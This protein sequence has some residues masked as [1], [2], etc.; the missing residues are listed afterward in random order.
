MD[1]LEEISL[2]EE[3]GQTEP[4]SVFMPIGVRRQRQP[5]QLI[6]PTRRA[7]PIPK[8]DEISLPLS[9]EFQA[10]PNEGQARSFAQ[11]I[12]EANPKVWASKDR[13]QR[14]KTLSATFDI[15]FSV[16]YEAEPGLS[17]SALAR[18]ANFFKYAG[19]NFMA[20]LGDL[21][22]GAGKA[23]EWAFG[24]SQ[25]SWMLY[26]Q[27]TVLQDRYAPPVKPHEFTLKSVADPE[28]WASVVFRNA[29]TTIGLAIAAVPG[30]YALSGAAAAFGATAFATALSY[31]ASSTT[32]AVVGAT[33]RAILQGLGA[34]ALMRP[35]ESA[36]EAGETLKQGQEAGLSEAE[37]L[38]R[39]NYTF[40]HNMALA[41]VDIAQIAAA[42]I[43]TKGIINPNLLARRIAAVTGKLGVVA[44]TESVEEIYQAGIQQSAMEPGLGITGALRRFN[45]EM[46]EAGAVGAIFGLGLGGAGS[47][48]TEMIN[49]IEAGMTPAQAQVYEQA[50]LRQEAKGL[51]P[52]TAT[53]AALD[54]FAA[55]PE[56]Y[57]SIVNS[58]QELRNV[59]EGKPTPILPEQMLAEIQEAAKIDDITIPESEVTRLLDEQQVFEEMAKGNVN[60]EDVLEL[61]PAPLPNWVKS[62]IQSLV[63]VA[64]NLGISDEI[65]ALSRQRLTAKQAAQ[66]IAENNPSISVSDAQ[67][68]V[69]AVRADRGIPSMDEVE[70]FER[71]VT[72]SVKS[73]EGK[74]N[75][76]VSEDS[77]QQA[78]NNIKEKSKGLHANIDPTIL[79]DYVK[80]GAYH[81][82][83][84]VR[85]LKGKST[86]IFAEWSNWMLKHFDESIRPNLQEIFQQ[87]WSM[88]QRG[89]APFVDEEGNRII[90][91]LDPEKVQ[92]RIET[93]KSIEEPTQPTKAVKPQ[94]RLTTGQKRIAKLVGEDV[95]LREALRRAERA[96]R[97]AY[98]A[99]AKD[100]LEEAKADMQDILIKAKV[101][102]ELFGFRE[103]FK[104]GERLTSKELT[105]MFLEKQKQVQQTRKALVDLI[106]EHLPMELRGRLLSM[107]AGNMTDSKVND[108]LD[109]IKEMSEEV[110][111][112]ELLD[113]IK[114]FQEGTFGAKIDIQYEKQIKEL[115]SGLNTKRITA[116][117]RAAAE[118]LQN[119]AAEF[120]MP[121]GVNAKMVD[122]IRRLEL[123][124]P[125]DMTTD[126]LRELRD[127]SVK[128][129]ELGKVKRQ[130][131]LKY[132]EEQRQA[133][134]KALIDSTHNIDFKITGDRDSNL[135]VSKRAVVDAYLKGL[136]SPR[137]VEMLD[138]WKHGENWKLLK[139][140]IDAST[141]ITWETRART[142]AA[143][144]ALA[145]ISGIDILDETWAAKFIAKV[146]RLQGGESQVK[147]L[148]EK[149]GFETLDELTAEE[150]KLVDVLREHG[151]ASKVDQTQA[152]WEET[153]GTE[154]VR[155]PNYTLPYKYVHEY[156][157]NPVESM[158]QGAYRSDTI[159]YGS[160]EERIEGVKRELRTDILG[161]L[162]ESIQDQE[163]FLGMYPVMDNIK[164]L[165]ATE[166]YAAAAGETAAN[167]WMNQ[168][169]IIARRGWTTAGA[170]AAGTPHGQFLKRSRMTMTQ[171][172]LAYRLTSFLIQPLAMFQAWAYVTQ[173]HGVIAGLEVVKEFAKTWAIPGKGK[174]IVA[175]SKALQNRQLGE[176]VVE[177]MAEMLAGKK[178]IRAQLMKHGLTALQWADV[179][180][181]AGVQQ[182]IEN[183][184]KRRG[185][186]NA[187]TTA[188]L[189]MNLA[190]GTSDVVLRP[191]L[192][193]QGP[194]ARTVLTFQSFVMNTA[195]IMFHDIINK[196]I[197]HSSDVKTKMTAL[198]AL[199]IMLAGKAA[200]DI[201]RD[202]NFAVLKNRR[203]REEKDLPFYLDA[204]FG[205][206]SHVPFFGDAVK[207]GAKGG[208]FDIPMTKA[209][210]DVVMWALGEGANVARVAEGTPQT[211]AQAKAIGRKRLRAAEALISVVPNSFSAGTGQF[212]DFI[213]SQLYPDEEPRLK[214]G[215]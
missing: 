149:H 67:E 119:Y 35:M 43:P 82:E 39:A 102:A 15:P 115:L 141:E 51:D 198:F 18:D 112:K 8:V 162:I 50:K 97:E 136:Y 28:W 213:E 109:R 186:P 111:R 195:N 181:A 19:Q 64:N 36:F 81:V 163:W 145:N 138:G 11:S 69:R 178:G 5:I 30:I 20:G 167:W 103:G 185:D 33:A 205:I 14:A 34:T 3:Y 215:R 127:M 153:Q 129:I 91:D 40:K 24:P 121:T 105:S 86:N 176:V 100:A 161:I 125:E 128:L 155:V 166:E 139:T 23:A 90:P 172:Q 122:T 27:G 118:W 38:R 199:T 110:E 47:V 63:N 113:E 143:L 120:G 46:K 66:Q 26:D 179:K 193:A 1:E 147:T 206:M 57:Q 174:D 137:V 88:V 62:N 197:V 79:A 65:E 151:P 98:K 209:V 75:F 180:T 191:Q 95:A 117:A 84:L 99:G 13:I 165:V 107:L 184:L 116:K 203:K 123:T 96:S 158:N 54:E 211:D 192:W 93:A 187:H 208:S 58:M 130:H 10:L 61:P 214:R 37:A 148:M 212:F 101:K 207:Y 56:G 190:S 59:A 80:V 133:K 114:K 7:K 94:I 16:A 132:N 146:A 89:I 157:A 171:A 188:E 78:L 134:S 150:M 71:W 32:A 202:F 196:G 200:E 210:T 44:A 22:A 87:S 31:G 135:N 126:D 60:I 124:Q 12:V 29:P 41:G 131:Q 170:R 4:S 72:T 140:A 92:E 21:Y 189:L 201:V 73:V 68:M 182:G 53:V 25:L 104:L 194:I 168:L 2:E 77:Y 152:M 144:D 17:Q 70:D 106:K 169:D 173:E 55:T 159:H 164:R 48:Y 160:G 175:A 42:L 6:Q 156:H 154:F 83:R 76:F 183:V 204:I 52:Q 142:S 9:P 108:I 49:R 85:K 74:E 177:E 45:P